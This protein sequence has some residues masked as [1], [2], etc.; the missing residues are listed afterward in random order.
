MPQDA[1]SPLDPHHC[2]AVI[3]F[4]QLVSAQGHIARFPGL[5]FTVK[6]TVPMLTVPLDVDAV[7][8]HRNRST[9]AGRGRSGFLKK[10]CDSIN[11]AGSGAWRV[12]RYLRGHL[13][14][15]R[16][17]VSTITGDGR[18]TSGAG[19]YSSRRVVVMAHSLT[20]SISPWSLPRPF[21]RPGR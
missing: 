8:Y 16:E 3:G 2:I 5:I 19:G 7:C 13:Q 1:R 9:P 17:R 18:H 21:F 11:R 4:I 15:T 20:R 14:Q 12:F 6:I 10:N